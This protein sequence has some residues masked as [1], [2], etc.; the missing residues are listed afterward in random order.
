MVGTGAVERKERGGAPRAMA[1]GE[2]PGPADEQP[3]PMGD[4]P[5]PPC[6][7]GPRAVRRGATARVAALRWPHYLPPVT[8]AELLAASVATAR[9]R[10]ARGRQRHARGG[11]RD[12]PLR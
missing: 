10:L 12:D 8:L 6:S 5:R 4:A 7:A 1:G 11:L 2:R 3:H 9:S